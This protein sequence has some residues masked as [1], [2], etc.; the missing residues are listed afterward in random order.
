MSRYLERW[1]SSNTLLDCVR[2]EDS[3]QTKYECVYSLVHRWCVCVWCVCVG[4]GGGGG[5]T[6]LMC[7]VMGPEKEWEMKYG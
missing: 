1:G 6:K 2:P 5:G 7:N 4:G 3:S